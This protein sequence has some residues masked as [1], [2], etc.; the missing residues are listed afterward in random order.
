VN[1]LQGKQ[2]Y[3]ITLLAGL[4]LRL[5]LVPFLM[6]VDP[7]FEGDLFAINQYAYFL[8]HGH[9]LAGGPYP[10]LALYTIGLFQTIWLPN[11]SQLLSTGS[12]LHLQSFLAP[13]LF[14]VVFVTKGLYLLFDVLTIWLWFL[15]F[16]KEHDKRRSAWLFWIF[17][18]LVI[19]NAYVHGGYELIPTYF[20]VLSLY[21]TSRGKLHWASLWL[22]IAACYKNFPFFFLPPLIIIMVW[23]RRDRFKLILWGIVPYILL[24]L[25]YWGSFGSSINS[26]TEWYFKVGYDLGFGA[27]IYIF[28]AFYAVLL[29]YL[30]QHKA[31]T[32][33]DFWRACFAI[34]LVYY[35]FSYFDLHY[36]V[37]VVPFAALYWVEYHREARPF[38]FVIGL[39]LLVLLA[40]TPIARFLAP[41]SPNF[42][43]RLPSL[44]EALN[45][46]LPM[47]LIIN[48]VRSL[49]AG[50]CFYLA[51]KL[52]RE[53]PSANNLPPHKTPN[54]STASGEIYADD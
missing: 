11:S 2:F 31:H 39:C 21:L 9:P 5:V 33:E 6:H 52:V 45:A 50:T 14:R 1:K 22:G 26:Y 20:L 23:S 24:I 44:M 54:I 30:Y 49:L 8:I 7:R 3:L 19:Y 12:D 37:W 47:L 46:Y 32:F 17:N 42:F 29:W 15:F 48:V 18:P 10:P 34:L 4:L 25:P 36:W 13:D 53:I 27:Q 28:L 35:Q 41:I 43:L 40:P 16:R 51:Y 38:Y